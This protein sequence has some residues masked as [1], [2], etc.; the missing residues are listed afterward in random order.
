[1]TTTAATAWPDRRTFLRV[2]SAGLLGLGLPDLLR[3]QAA[4]KGR[5]RAEGVILLWL[6]GGP[7]TI[8]MWDLKPDAPEEVRG[9]FK[10]IATRAKG[11]MICE[12][13]PRTARVMDRCV[14]VRSLAHSIP[15]HGVATRYMTTGN[16]PS[17][18]LEHPSLGSLAARVLPPPAGLPSYVAFGERGGRASGAGYLGPAYN[19]FEFEGDPAR[20][21]L[22]MEGLGL[23]D[24]F[25]LA[26]LSDR[27]RLRAKFD[28][29]FAALDRAGLPASLDEFHQQAL[30]LLRSDRT[31]HALELDR[32]PA[33]VR[34]RYGRSAFGQGVLAARRLV[35]AGVSFA[36]VTLGGWDTHA[37][38][39]GAL[40]GN[41]LP[42]LDTALA[43]LVADLEA[44]GLLDR[45]VVYCAGEF[46][47]TPRINRSNGRDH[48][49][50]SMAVLLAGGGFSRG[51]VHGRTDSRGI[52]PAADACSPDDVS[53]TV[54]QAL[55]IGP[56]HELHTPA[57]RPIALFRD[58]KVIEGLLARG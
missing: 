36:T 20:G 17:P 13:L 54:F 24:G 35:E 5:P 4:V 37:G 19:P 12:H 47:R 30:D 42:R 55:G 11:V 15:E 41:L 7:A 2:G 29:R 1:M 31:R 26:D 52:A 57:G 45:T 44:R 22:R 38:N 58:G 33:A 48:W 25:T 3:L 21:Q 50:R 51:H 18:A 46:G 10:P 40:R 27:D 49:S 14:L 39:F 34:E 8:D 56:R 53:A 9:E 16:L 32:E 28:R 6:S 23:P 43:A